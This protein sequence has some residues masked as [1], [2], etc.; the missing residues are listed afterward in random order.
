MLRADSACRHRPSGHNTGD[1]RSAPLT[2]WE[3]HLRVIGSII[4]IEDITSE[5]GVNVPYRGG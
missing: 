5:L 4:T 3:P 2:L 1:S